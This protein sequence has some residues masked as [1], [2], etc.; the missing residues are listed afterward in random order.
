[1]ITS[2]PLRHLKVSGGDL[3]EILEW[4]GDVCRGDGGAYCVPLNLSKYVKAKSDPK[5][6]EAILGADLVIADGVPITWLAR[7]LGYSD[8]ARVTGIGLA[9]AVLGASRERGWKVFLFGASSQYLEGALAN[10][11][12]KFSH[13]LIAGWR[14]GYFSEADVP[15]IVG[16]INVSGADILLLALGMP[17]K[18]YFIA[19]HRHELRTKF[20]LPVGGAV[21]IWAGSKTRTPPFIQSVGLEWL[22]RSWYDRSRAQLILKHGLAFL[23]DLLRPR[24]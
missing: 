18:E 13:P 20:C 11:E 3:P 22:Y 4:V 21:D 7:R 9:E 1:M 10:I 6:R 8:V 17:Q 16:Q 14:D 24:A 15:G 23:R 19:D 2:H 12:T 5:L